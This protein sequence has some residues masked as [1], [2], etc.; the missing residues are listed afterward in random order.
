MVFS[1]LALNYILYI[2]ALYTLEGIL[3]ALPRPG[4]F[5]GGGLFE[6]KEKGEETEKG[7]GIEGMK[8]RE[9]R[10]ENIPGMILLTTALETVVRRQQLRSIRLEH[11]VTGSTDLFARKRR[12]HTARLSPVTTAVCVLVLYVSKQP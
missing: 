7:Q 8:G 5:E 4:R 2:N 1:S 10:G 3:T 12:V 9:W 11:S 6:V